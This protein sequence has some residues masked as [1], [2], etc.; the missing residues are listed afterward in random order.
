MEDVRWLLVND[1]QGRGLLIKSTDNFSVPDIASGKI[2]LS[3]GQGAF[4]FAVRPLFTE[5]ED[6]VREARTLPCVG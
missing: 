3:G 4:S 1:K 6:V 5:D 2:S